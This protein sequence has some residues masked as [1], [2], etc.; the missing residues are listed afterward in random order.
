MFWMHPSMEK[1]LE[2]HFPNLV[3]HSSFF[4]KLDLNLLV[5]LFGTTRE[6]DMLLTPHTHALW[7]SDVTS[8]LDLK[9]IRYSV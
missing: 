3:P 2:R 4:F 6:D 8:C 9:K 7:L 1:V 5:T